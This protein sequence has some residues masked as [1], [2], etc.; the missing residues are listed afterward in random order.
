MGKDEDFTGDILPP[1][2]DK[3]DAKVAGVMIGVVVTICGCAIILAA[4]IKACMI[5]LG[6]DFD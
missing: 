6:L 2:K 5:I 3:Q 4:T 1:H